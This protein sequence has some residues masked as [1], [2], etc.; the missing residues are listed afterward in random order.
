MSN[1]QYEVQHRL[2]ECPADVCRDLVHSVHLRQPL[3]VQTRSGEEVVEEEEEEVQIHSTR[4]PEQI[5]LP[6][7]PAL[8]L[9]NNNRVVLVPRQI[10]IAHKS[11]LG[12]ENLFV[13][14]SVQR[15]A[16]ERKNG[17]TH[18]TNSAFFQF[19]IVQ[20]YKSQQNTE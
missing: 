11:S 9:S 6:T 10:A 17:R 16:K 18:H 13:A 19:Y 4:L 20:N 15:D 14:R 12:V 5:R 8:C 1:E 2:C 3:A 7:T